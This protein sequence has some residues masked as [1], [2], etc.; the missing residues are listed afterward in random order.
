MERPTSKDTST[1]YDATDRR[2]CE[3]FSWKP[4]APIRYMHLDGEE[5]TS[6][7]PANSG[8]LCHGLKQPRSCK[9]PE[10]RCCRRQVSALSPRGCTNRR[11]GGGTLVRTNLR[12][13]NKHETPTISL[14]RRSRITSTR[15]S[16]GNVQCR[17]LPSAALAYIW[18]RRWSTATNTKRVTGLTRND[19]K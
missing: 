7:E 12:A 5:R 10:C 16:A 11:N 19:V 13:N 2:Y 9:I 14:I 15:G 1:T 18:R 6:A 4:C 3:A 17:N 8:L